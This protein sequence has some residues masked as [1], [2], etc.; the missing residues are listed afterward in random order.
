MNGHH[1]SINYGPSY[2]ISLV[3]RI[4]G[5]DFDVDLVYVVFVAQPLDFKETVELLRFIL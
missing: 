2:L 1:L 3:G 5:G 4:L